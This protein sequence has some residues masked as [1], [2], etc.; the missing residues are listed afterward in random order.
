MSI[1]TTFL[2]RCIGTLETAFGETGKLRDIAPVDGICSTDIVVVV[3]PD[4]RW[5]AFT[6]ACLSSDEFVDYTDQT[7]TG[8]KMP[9]TIWKTMCQYNICVPSEQVIRAYQGIVQSLLDLVG[10][11]ILEARPR[12]NPRSSPPEADV[13]RNRPFRYREG[14]RG[15]GVNSPGGEV[16]VYES[17]DGEVR[18]DVRFD[19][20]TVWLTQRQMAELFGPDRSVIARHIHNAYR[21]QEL[22]PRSTCANFAQVR[23]EGGGEYSRSLGR[24]ERRP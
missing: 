24:P 3:S 21:E 15:R 1:D 6:L 12:S 20:E 7:S 22:H 13:R 5:E 9:R 4:S 16:I 10:L 18:V 19:K 8:T 11:N 2:R 23:S 14:S 17:G